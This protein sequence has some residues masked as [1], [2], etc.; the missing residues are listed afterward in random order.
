MNWWGAGIKRRAF[1]VPAAPR[2]SDG[3]LIPGSRRLSVIDYAAGAGGEPARRQWRERSY[4]RRGS[5]VGMYCSRDCLANGHDC[6]GASPLDEAFRRHG[7]E[8]ADQDGSVEVT[9]AGVIPDIVI[10]PH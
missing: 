9:A 8:R 10:R 1:G 4:E 5:I 6:D 2:D 7:L 3:D